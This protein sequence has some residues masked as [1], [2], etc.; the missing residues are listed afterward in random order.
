MMNSKRL[1]IGILT[2]RLYRF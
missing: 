1:K 2:L